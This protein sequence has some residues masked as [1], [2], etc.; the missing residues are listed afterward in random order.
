MPRSNGSE[1]KV[2]ER[3]EFFV[4]YEAVNMTLESLRQD[5]KK[6]ILYTLNATLLSHAN[7]ACSR[8]HM[9]EILRNLGQWWE[10]VK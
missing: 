6:H 5:A 7:G 9:N 10:S 3:G 4:T 2:T 1:N 8:E